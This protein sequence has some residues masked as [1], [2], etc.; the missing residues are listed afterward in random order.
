MEKNLK[1]EYDCKMTLIKIS[2]YGQ[3]LKTWIL[4]CACAYWF[5]KI[6]QAKVNIRTEFSLHVSCRAM[7]HNFINSSVR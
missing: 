6:F 1:E 4:V 2:A 5:V 3:V 7:K